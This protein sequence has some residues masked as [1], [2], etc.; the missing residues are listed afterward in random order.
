MSN[1]SRPAAAA[2]KTHGDAMGTPSSV[3]VGFKKTSQTAGSF[4][5]LSLTAAELSRL[6]V[7]EKGRIALG[8]FIARPYK[9][10][11]TGKT[12]TPKFDYRVVAMRAN[13]NNKTENHDTAAD[14]DELP[15]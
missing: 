4:I 1:Y 10:K 12:S 9:D 6:E 8:V 2:K 5:V 13:N 15:L 7:D 3:G 14:D 11:K